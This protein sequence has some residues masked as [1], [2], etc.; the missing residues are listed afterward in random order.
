MLDP[1]N[2]FADLPRL[3]K[4]IEAA[5]ILRRTPRTIRRWISL[6]LLQAVRPAGGNPLIP[7]SEIERLLTEGA[8]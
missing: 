6:G 4:P 2:Q 5:N 8:A 7:R 1:E 3:L